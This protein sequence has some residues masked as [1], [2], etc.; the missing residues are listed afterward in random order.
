MTCNNVRGIMYLFL[1]AILV[2]VPV[3]GKA[4]LIS[5]KSVPVANGDQFLVLPSE[6][7]GMGSVAVALNDRLLDPF[8]N[9][10]TGSRTQ[11]VQFFGSPTAYNITDNNGSAI[12]LPFGLL[13]GGDTWF[14]GVSAAIQ[15]VTAPENNIFIQPFIDWIPVRNN[16]TVLLSDKSKNNTFISGSIGN[17]L[18]TSGINVAAGLSW[19]NL[20]AVDGVELLYVN[21]EK[22]EQ[23]GNMLDLR[24]GLVKDQINEYAFEALLI[25]NR[26]DMTHD[27]TYPTWFGPEERLNNDRVERNLDQTRTWGL[28]FRYA[29]PLTKQNWYIGGIITA[30]RKT[31]PKIPNYDLMNIPRDPGDTWAYNF[32]LGLSR[33]DSA[34]KFGI[35]LI[36]EP[37][38]SNTWADTPVPILNQSGNIIPAGGKTVINDFMFTNWIFRF[39]VGKQYKVFGFQLGLQTR[40]YNYNLEQVNKV[41]IFERSQNENWTEWTPS[42]GLNLDFSEFQVK[43]TGRLT[44]GTGRPG[45]ARDWPIAE[46]LQFAQSADFILA[47]DGALT[48]QDATVFTHQVYVVVPIGQK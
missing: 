44:T 1:L 48:L 14:G 8:I 45:V 16:S 12:T 2:C 41:E 10:A 32:G 3:S 33:K 6:N 19:S 23:F 4:Q 31:H 29:Q 40:F 30:N 43:Y 13:F 35:D 38:W 20:N 36:F 9:P 5:L 11:S 17:Q 28:H 34:A 24:L 25:H 22:I 15:Q 46:D 37:I 42:I 27:V 47:P 7:L 18:G 21:S 39:G 26:I